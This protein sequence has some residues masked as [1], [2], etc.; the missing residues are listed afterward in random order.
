MT[1][2]F[3]LLDTTGFAPK[4]KS[5]GVRAT[6]ARRAA[7]GTVDTDEKDIAGGV[8]AEDGERRGDAR[9]PRAKKKRPRS[10]RD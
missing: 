6:R 3:Q 10:L 4:T 9:S 1:A 7:G 2:S 5:P 8:S